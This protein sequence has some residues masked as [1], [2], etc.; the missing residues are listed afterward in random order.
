[1]VL[2]IEIFLPYQCLPRAKV[3]FSHLFQ[4]SLVALQL[5]S[6]TMLFGS[7][8]MVERPHK[9][10]MTFLIHVVPRELDPVQHWFISFF[11]G[12]PCILTGRT[13]AINNMSN[14]HQIGIV[15]MQL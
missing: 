4:F 5:E 14:L 2:C 11:T 1:M 12:Y 8:T 7:D 10:G 6:S 3:S 13:I 9:R 15:C